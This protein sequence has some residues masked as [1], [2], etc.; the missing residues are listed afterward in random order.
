MPCILGKASS[1]SAR[2][3]GPCEYPFE[4]IES[5]PTVGVIVI[6]HS[7]KYPNQRHCVCVF[8]ALKW[9]IIMNFAA[10]ETS[11]ASPHC[12][13]AVNVLMCSYCSKHGE[14]KLFMES[15]SIPGQAPRRHIITQK[16]PVRRTRWKVEELMQSW[17]NYRIST[18]RERKSEGFKGSC[19]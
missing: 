13:M 3:K 4:K 1:L 12:C 6:E 2:S 5:A 8:C 18:Q 15:T 16:S 10:W 9:T 7:F 11:L 14:L 19:K 17:E